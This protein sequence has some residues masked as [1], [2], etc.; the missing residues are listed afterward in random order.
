MLEDR[1]FSATDVVLLDESHAAGT[2]TEVGGAPTFIHAL[3]A[4]SFEGARFVF[5]AGN[6]QTAASNWEAALGSGASV[7]DLTGGIPDS[8]GAFTWI[9]SLDAVL[10]APSAV[11]GSAAS[12]ASK[13]ATK[14]PLY[15]SAGTALIIASSICAAFREF[16]PNRVVLTF[17]PPTSEAGQ[18]GV[19]ELETQSASLLSFRSF[20]RSVFDAQV[21]FNLL[22]AYGPE[23]KRN[24][25]E[26]RDRLGRE[27]A[28]YLDGRALLPAIQF[29]QAAVF[30]GYA[31]SV[32]AEFAAPPDGTKLAA[33]IAAAGMKLVKKGETAPDNISA[34]GES[35][36]QI[37]ELERDP[38]VTN[39]YWCWGVADNLRLA[40]TNAVRIAEELFV[41]PA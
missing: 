25:R 4:D 22:T 40:A 24:L 5:F 17:Y 10:P 41:I 36:I 29:V 11:V 35:E 3:D 13:S 6:P 2:L 30:Y 37:G 32:Y 20:E 7:I 33:A 23:S 8:T 26:M 1:N 38:N 14:R 28:G 34:A 19:D 12:S 15:R 18:A 39:G 31:F 16:A 9:P 27:I 21:A